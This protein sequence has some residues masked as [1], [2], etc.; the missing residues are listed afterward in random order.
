MDVDVPDIR[1]KVSA[2]YPGRSIALPRLRA[3][4]LRRAGMSYQRRETLGR[5]TPTSRGSREH[6]RSRDDD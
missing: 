4:T 5:S 1:A 3:E 2:H 6:S